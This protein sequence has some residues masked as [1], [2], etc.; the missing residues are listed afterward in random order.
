MKG[1]TTSTHNVH[2]RWEP[3]V[4][5]NKFCHHLSLVDGEL[6]RCMKATKGKTYCPDCDRHLITLTDRKP[7]EPV[8][9]ASHPWRKPMKL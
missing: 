9:D 3:K 1:T 7:T 5:G 6:I 4:Y 8:V 2:K